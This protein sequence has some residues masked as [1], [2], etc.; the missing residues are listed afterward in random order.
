MPTAQPHYLLQAEVRFSPE[1]DSSPQWHFLLE[2]LDGSSRLEV[3]DDEPEAP[4]DRLELLAL[5]RGLEAL[6]QPARVTLVTS[7]KY[8]NH[9]LRFGLDQWRENGWQWE[10]FGQMTAIK[11]EDLWR[12]ID[13]AITIH[14]VEC[15][16]A[17][18][19]A[20]SVER[21]DLQTP[22]MIVDRADPAHAELPA[23]HERSLPRRKVAAVRTSK[24]PPLAKQ[25]RVKRSTP[26]PGARQ[27]G[28][29]QTGIWQMG[30]WQN[31]RAGVAHWLHGLGTAVAPPDTV[32]SH[33]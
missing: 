19:E 27:A 21:N 28:S 29:W 6:D 14:R 1:N 13:Q 9:G 17:R 3:A 30:I 2:S 16:A 25:P 7:S 26:N 4:S 22:A 10:A 32:A 20:G 5:V 33:S 18:G 31:V 23:P 15:K 11:N 24:A 12:R 8:V